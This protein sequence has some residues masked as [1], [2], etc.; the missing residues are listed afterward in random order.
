MC[1][2]VLCRQALDRVPSVL[3][4]TPRCN[5]ERAKP[6]ECSQLFLWMKLMW[7]DIRRFPPPCHMHV[8]THKH[9]NTN[10]HSGE[11]VNFCINRWFRVDW[12]K[13]DYFANCL[14]SRLS[15]CLSVCHTF[16]ELSHI[17]HCIPHNLSTASNKDDEW[18]HLLSLYRSHSRS[19]LRLDE[20][21]FRRLIIIQFPQ[22]ILP[23]LWSRK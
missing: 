5:R 21:F 10:G 3:Q 4:A 19:L 16:N 7:N 17:S 8:H 23:R 9:I 13:L 22:V 20:C 15:V 14:S 1:E 6:E 12:F 18:P 2:R 11:W